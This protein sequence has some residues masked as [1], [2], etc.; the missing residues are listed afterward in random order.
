MLH[1]ESLPTCFHKSSVH[2]SLLNS[3]SVGLLG[4][5]LAGICGA[6]VAS[7][8]ST[9][10]VAPSPSSCKGLNTLGF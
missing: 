3:R 7:A 5:N 10:A 9:V 6:L 1:A 2:L 8:C 4:S